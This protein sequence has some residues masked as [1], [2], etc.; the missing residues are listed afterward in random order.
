MAKFGI[1]LLLVFQGA[2]CQI[3]EADCLESDI[4]CPGQEWL[5]FRAAIAS[6]SA[7]AA[8]TGCPATNRFLVIHGGGLASTSI[9]NPATNSFS[10][11]PTLLTAPGNGA[12]AIRLP[13]ASSDR[14]KVLVVR[15]GG[16]ATTNIINPETMAVTAGPPLSGNA[17][18]GSAS[19]VIPNGPGKDDILTVHAGAANNQTSR[20]N[21]AS[22]TYSAGPSFPA[23]SGVALHLPILSGPHSGKELVWYASGGP[24]TARLDYS[25]LTFAG[26]P[27]DPFTSSAGANVFAGMAGAQSGN[28]IHITGS[29][30]LNTSVYQAG[31]NTMVVGATLPSGA[32]GGSQS[33]YINSGPNAGKQLLFLN[34]TNTAL[35]DHTLDTFAA[36]P[37]LGVAFFT[38]RNFTIPSGPQAGNHL[39]VL[40]SANQTR[41]YNESTG[42]FGAGPTTTANVA[43]TDINIIPFP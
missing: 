35:Y 17:N 23:F 26:G 7:A 39:V 27:N 22:M 25:T 8:T 34:G 30:S 40:A 20:L 32:F 18:Q 37:G 12:H 41:I 6:L 14:C 2:A 11:G 28:I 21:V 3:A 24:N 31:A 15:G 33:F 9:Y 4:S 19:W 36:G 1:A 38:S 29:G 43:N 42:T 10:A 13:F 16:T 5:L